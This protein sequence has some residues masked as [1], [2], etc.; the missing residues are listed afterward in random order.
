MN[1]H[2]LLIEGHV[3]SKKNEYAIRRYPNGKNSFYIP[4]DVKADLDAIQYQM[5]KQWGKRPT[6][7]HP[8]VVF[9]LYAKTS[10]S[11]RDNRVQTLIDCMVKAGVIADDN[12]AK[13]NGYVLITPCIVGGPEKSVI[14]LTWTDEGQEA[15]IVA[16]KAA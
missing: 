9:H 1:Q 5:A 12:I 13:F 14:N 2:T 7:V 6:L 11:D 8:N 16:K 4:A 15:A 3:P 10:R